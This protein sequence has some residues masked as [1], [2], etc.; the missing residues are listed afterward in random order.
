MSKKKRERKYRA[1]FYQQ[2]ELPQDT[3]HH[4]RPWSRSQDDRWENKVKV[5]ENLHQKF[6]AL[7]I[8]RTP[9]EVIEFLL[10]YFFGGRTQILRN[11]LKRREAK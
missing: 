5:N 2:W 4:I 6:H 1:E 11:V 9:E 7:F 10:D 3:E 8:N